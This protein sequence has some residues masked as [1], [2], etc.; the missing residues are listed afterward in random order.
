LLPAAGQPPPAQVRFRN[1][2]LKQVLPLRQHSGALA[3]DRATVCLLARGD[4]VALDRLSPSEALALMGPP[5]PGFDLLAGDIRAASELLA[6]R[7]A[8]RLTLSANP[9]EAIACLAANLP[10]LHDTAVP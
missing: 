7:G 1:G 9:A 8:W 5:E 6:S 2:K 10:R 4:A 3:A